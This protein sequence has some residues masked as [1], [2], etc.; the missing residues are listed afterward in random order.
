MPTAV[1]SQQAGSGVESRAQWGEQ[2][3]RLEEGYKIRPWWSDLSRRPFILC[4]L[5]NEKG[6]N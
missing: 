5:P 3:G 4:L 1:A 6:M 2:G